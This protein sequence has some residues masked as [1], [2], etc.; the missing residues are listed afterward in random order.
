MSILPPNQPKI[1]DKTPTKFFIWGPSMS[2]K[3]YL[4]RQF[5]NTLILYTD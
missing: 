5:P 1:A 3:T 4:A 2:G